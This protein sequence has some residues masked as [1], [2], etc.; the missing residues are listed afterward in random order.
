M[1][2]E[3][4]DVGASLKRFREEFKLRQGEV[5]ESIGILQQLY[6]KYETGRVTPSA[7]IIYKLAKTYN[8]SADYLLGLSDNPSPTDKRLIEAINSCH[9][10]LND[11]LTKRVANE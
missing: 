6:Y 9:E 2:Q 4:P 3:E 7:N 1:I 11:V 5:A 10:I 8:V